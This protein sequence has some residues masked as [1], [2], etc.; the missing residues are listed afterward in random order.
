MLF[1]GAPGVQML[2]CAAGL[3]G[4]VNINSEWAVTLSVSFIPDHEN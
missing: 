3:F 2:C 1:P 4:A